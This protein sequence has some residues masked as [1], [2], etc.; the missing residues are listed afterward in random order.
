IVGIIATATIA[1]SE[2]QI[3]DTRLYA[4]LQVTS[5][6]IGKRLWNAD[7]RCGRACIGNIG[8]ARNRISRHHNISCAVIIVNEKETVCLILR[9]KC[10]AEQPMFAIIYNDAA[11]IKK[12][13]GQKSSA[14][15]DA[16]GT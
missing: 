8:I 16:D 4:E 10:H 13:R 6:V 9:M 14:I 1:C 12:W 5:I 15:P 11:D 3:V 7:E 2:I